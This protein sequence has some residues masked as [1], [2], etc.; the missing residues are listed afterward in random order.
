MSRVNGTEIYFSHEEI[1]DALKN[2]NKEY[3]DGNI[4][5]KIEYRLWQKLK[6]SRDVTFLTYDEFI[7]MARYQLYRIK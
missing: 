6:K 1:C 7:E 3:K 5:E 4:K 2:F